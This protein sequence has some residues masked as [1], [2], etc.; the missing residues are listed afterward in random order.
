MEEK[1][2]KMIFHIADVHLRNLR[3]H[4]ESKEVLN[5]FVEMC[6]NIINENG[7]SP[8]EVRVIIAGDLFHQK[9]QISNE[10]LVLVSNFLIKL[11]N[12]ATTYIMAGNHDMIVSNKDRLDSITPLF[13]LVDFERTSFLDMEL[14]YKSGIIED[15]NVMWVLYSIFDDYIKPDLIDVKIDFPD[16]KF[17][18]LF[19][20]PII[21]SSTDVGYV[22]DKGISPTIFEGCDLVLCGDIHKRQ[23]LKI[24][25]TPIVY[26]GSLIQQNYGE[27]VKGH[28][29][30]VWDLVNN[31]NKFYEIEND[32][33]YYKIEIDNVDDI[34]EDK[35]RFINLG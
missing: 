16:K 18:G 34:K 10:L 27:N 21:G 20:G 25:K 35:E 7:Y 1:D 33:S 8:E 3:R 2:I 24:G 28:G 15:N 31:K 26:S 13:S 23:S 6:E 4:E 17:I 14:D 9:I 30:L 12:I 19:H 22:M 32:Y 29:F 11:D 5:K